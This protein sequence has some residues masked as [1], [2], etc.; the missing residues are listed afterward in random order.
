MLQDTGNTALLFHPAWNLTW[1]GVSEITRPIAPRT[2]LQI[3]FKL[4]Q[5][6]RSA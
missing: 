5:E 3:F 6:A 4:R 1:H 2:S